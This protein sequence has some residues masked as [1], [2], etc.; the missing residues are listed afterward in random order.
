MRR[1]EDRWP[2]WLIRWARRGLSGGLHSTVVVVVDNVIG[3]VSGV[4]VVSVRVCDL[5]VLNL[6]LVM[7]QL[8]LC[9]S[10]NHR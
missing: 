3:G 8:D 4:G 2:D 6:G 10:Q 7:L 5:E 9:N 1:W